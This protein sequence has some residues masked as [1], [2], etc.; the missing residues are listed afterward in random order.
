M[1]AEE[2]IEKAKKARKHIEK[3]RACLRD[4]MRSD[5]QKEEEI[6]K[7]YDE[8][9]SADFGIRFFHCQLEDYLERCGK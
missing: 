5:S 1:E 7:A 8:L 2:K 3:A 6:E 9:E 4:I